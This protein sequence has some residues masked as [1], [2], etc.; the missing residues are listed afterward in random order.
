MLA[1]SVVENVGSVATAIGTLALAVVTY[2][3]VTKTRELAG[4]TAD[5]AE[6]GRQAALTGDRQLQELKNQAVEARRQS[7]AAETALN[8]SVRAL[9]VNVPFGTGLKIPLGPEPPGGFRQTEPG[10]PD[11]T[12]PLDLAT[13]NDELNS[14]DDALLYLPV[15]NVGPG[16]AVFVRDKTRVTLDAT[17]RPVVPG[18]TAVDVLAP[19]EA[20]YL[21]FRSDAERE[22]GDLAL[23]LSKAEHL[24]VE[25]AY[26]D[27]SGRQ[28]A[29]TQIKIGRRD[30]TGRYDVA[31]VFFRE[32]ESPPPEGPSA[33]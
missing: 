23:I 14:L 17:R 18:I 11:P 19:G 20:T 6:S 16:V 21:V 2:A 31:R 29:A 28:E 8:A 3:M 7:N 32:P 13:I 33:V 12:P 10:A 1:A 25:V 27:L 9:I 24:I 26:T 15:R 30:D 5:L 22:E 4:K